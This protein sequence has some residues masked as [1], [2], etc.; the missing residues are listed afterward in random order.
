M[1]IL[2][3]RGIW[4]NA[5]DKNSLSSLSE[6]LDYGFGVELDIRDYK[7]RLVISHDVPIGKEPLWEDFLEIYSNKN[8]KSDIAIN[9]KSDGLHGLIEKSIINFNLENFFLFDMAVPDMR[10][11]LA[12][13]LPVY[14]RFSDLESAPVLLKSVSGL[15]F[16]SFISEVWYDP[17]QINA[18]L[19]SGLSISFVSP[20]LH[21]YDMNP[22]WFFI[23]A[24]GFH[25]HNNVYICTDH[26]VEAKDFFK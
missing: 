16:D 5:S 7:G 8:I 17:A 18:Y 19:D 21:G 25:R 2:A 15:W 11:Y 24:E 3:H 13:C 22:M 9:V 26:P 12:K 10:G 20:E 14:T 6:A 4:R 23:R 1:K